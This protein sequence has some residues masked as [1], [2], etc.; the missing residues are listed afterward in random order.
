MPEANKTMVRRLVEEM[1]NRGNLAIIDERFASDYLG[2]STTKT[3]GPEGAK[4]FAAA[5]RS[6]FAGFHCTIEDQIAEGD[7]VVTRWTVRGIHE[8]EFEGIP[9]TG[10]PSTVTGI[11]VFRIADGK[12]I[13]GWTNANVLDALDA[14]HQRDHVPASPVMTMREE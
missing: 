4:A 9:P 14:T 8:G 3:R 1:W 2:H 13:E 6:A 10:E 5:L 11:T 7:R 12:I